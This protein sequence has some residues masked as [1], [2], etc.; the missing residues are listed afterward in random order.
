MARLKKTE[1]PASSPEETVA[2][3]TLDKQEQDEAK[4]VAAKIPE[5][6]LAPGKDPFEG[7]GNALE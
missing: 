6:D 1:A 7:L 5:A 3:A 2:V 4:P